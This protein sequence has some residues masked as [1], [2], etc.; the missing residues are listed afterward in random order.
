M[1]L[2]HFL[3]FFVLVLFLKHRST[4]FLISDIK[5][6]KIFVRLIKSHLNQ[7]VKYFTGENKQNIKTKQ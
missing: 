1:F 3:F 6:A 5:E 2:V 4:L 7:K